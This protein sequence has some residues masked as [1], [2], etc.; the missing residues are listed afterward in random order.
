MQQEQCDGRRKCGYCNVHDISK[1]N[2]PYHQS[3]EAGIAWQ[4]YMSDVIQ[5]T[6]VGLCTNVM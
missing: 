6:L 2:L 3:D 4:K 1:T 5:S